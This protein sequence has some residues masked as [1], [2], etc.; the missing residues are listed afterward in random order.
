M[1][2]RIICSSKCDLSG[3]GAAANTGLGVLPQA[4][5]LTQAQIAQLANLAQQQRNVNLAA[6]DNLARAELIN[7]LNMLQNQELI[8][9][10]AI[11]QQVGHD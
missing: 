11:Q 10:A 9:Q 4:N 1:A 7:Q 2:L 3:E 8:K 5:G 6:R